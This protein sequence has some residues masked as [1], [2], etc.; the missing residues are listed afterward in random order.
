MRGLRKLAM[1]FDGNSGGAMGVSGRTSEVG[2]LVKSSDVA[3]VDSLQQSAVVAL[4][5]TALQ[6]LH[7][8]PI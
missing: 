6:C 7:L 1:L 3:V 8:A 2:V 5:T 4:F